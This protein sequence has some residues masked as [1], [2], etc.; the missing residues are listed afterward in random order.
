MFYSQMSLF[1][2]ALNQTNDIAR[3]KAVGEL[4]AYIPPLGNNTD[5]LL[6]IPDSKMNPDYGVS[7]GRGLFNFGLGGGIWRTIATRVRLNTPG[8][9]DGTRPLN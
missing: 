1:V 6:A 5:R 8:E 2:P 9:Q 3:P 7:V 4:Y